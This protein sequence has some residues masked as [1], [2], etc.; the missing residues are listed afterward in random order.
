MLLAISDNGDGVTVSDSGAFELGSKD[1]D[2]NNEMV[3][4]EDRRVLKALDTIRMPS[5]LYYKLYG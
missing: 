2:R 3:S 5:T 1:N 4:N